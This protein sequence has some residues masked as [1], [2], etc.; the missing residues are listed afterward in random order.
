MRVLHSVL[1]QVVEGGHELPAVGED[2]KPRGRLRRVDDDATLIGRRPHALHRLRHHEV[3]GD[4][5]AQGG[6]F[7]LDATQV[8]QVV[9]DPRHPLRFELHARREA[10][11]DVGI[12]LAS[13]GLGQQA[14]RSHRGLQLVADVGDEVTPHGIHSPA[15]GH[16]LDHD[17]SA[18][19]PPAVVERHGHDVQRAPGRTVE[20]ERARLRLA[21]HDPPNQLQDRPLGEEVG[22]AGP[23]ERRSLFVAVDDLAVLVTH[24]DAQRHRAEGA[25]EPTD[26]DLGGR[27]TGDGLRRRVLEALEAPFR[28]SASDPFRVG[29]PAAVQP[30]RDRGQPARQRPPVQQHPEHDDNRDATRH[31]DA[32]D[33]PAHWVASSSNCSTSAR[34]VDASTSSTARTPTRAVTAA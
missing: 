28:A 10:T 33:R 9:D 5:L 27:H 22:V 29:F 8:E 19:A 3:H 21:L 34:A 1:E 31:E 7:R 32:G 17:G 12:V 16:V 25:L 14:E 20:V 24:H 15:F 18:D 23:D 2:R 11:D 30:G 4:R 26:P 6:L 13:E